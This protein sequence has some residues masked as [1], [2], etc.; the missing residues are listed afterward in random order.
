MRKLSEIKL[1]STP[2]S[3]GVELGEVQTGEF[4]LRTGNLCVCLEKGAYLEILQRRIRHDNRAL[5]VS[6]VDVSIAY[7]KES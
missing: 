3:E 7:P 6:I 4:F 1:I 2:P 5:R